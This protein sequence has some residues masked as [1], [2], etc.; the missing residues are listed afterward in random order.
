MLFV[1][2]VWHSLKMKL[3]N[4]LAHNRDRLKERKKQSQK[5]PKEKKK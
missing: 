5:E 4:Q 3:D 1:G 2:W